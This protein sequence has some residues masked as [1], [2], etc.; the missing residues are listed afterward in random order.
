MTPFQ[1][2]ERRWK[3]GPVARVKFGSASARHRGAPRLP[4]SHGRQ[5]GDPR[6][7][8]ICPLHGEAA[9]GAAAERAGEGTRARPD[10]HAVLDFN[11]TGEEFL[12]GVADYL[13]AQAKRW[14]SFYRKLHESPGDLRAIHCVNVPQAMKYPVVGWQRCGVNNDRQL[15]GDLG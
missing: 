2:H 14:G 15:L 8:R 12:L 13:H 11:R 7:A 6:V 9:P 5:T 10:R 1:R 4:Q 3:A